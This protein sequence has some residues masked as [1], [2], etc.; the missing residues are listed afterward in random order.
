[1]TIRAEYVPPKPPA[2]HALHIPAELGKRLAAA[3]GPELE[4]RFRELS[5]EY[6]TMKR[7]HVQYWDGSVCRDI[8]SEGKT[9]YYLVLKRPVGEDE[10][11][12]IMLLRSFLGENE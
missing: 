9:E 6:G 2:G 8:V 12:M 1:M 10:S 5:I 11:G 4:V 7:G 3:F